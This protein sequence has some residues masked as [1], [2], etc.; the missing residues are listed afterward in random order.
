MGV[1]AAAASVG[2]AATGVSVGAA[3]GAG[4][5]VGAAV[6]AGVSVGTAVG[7]GVSVGAAAGADVSTGTVVGVGVGAGAQAPNNTDTMSTMLST[8]VYLIF[9]LVSP[10]YIPALLVIVWGD[11]NI[12]LQL[13]CNGFSFHD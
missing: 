12:P 7:A 11:S 3:V 1:S 8:A 9:I 13:T 2:A 6:G 5:S 10:R 4:V